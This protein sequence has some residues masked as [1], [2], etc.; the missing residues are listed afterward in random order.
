VLDEG[1]PP[2]APWLLAPG[3]AM[4]EVLDAGGSSLLTAVNYGIFEKKILL[5]NVDLYIQNFL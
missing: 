3:S 1:L 5:Y 4:S 2:S